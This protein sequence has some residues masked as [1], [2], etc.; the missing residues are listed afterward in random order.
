MATTLRAQTEATAAID[1]KVIC[2]FPRFDQNPITLDQRLR[3]R[4][5]R[6][7]TA[8]R[9]VIPNYC[10]CA[11]DYQLSSWD[12]GQLRNFIQNRIE[13]CLRHLRFDSRLLWR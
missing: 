10:F 13:D 5:A 11:N 12:T 4:H 1:A 2:L 8:K 6:F 3:V 7:R 9:A